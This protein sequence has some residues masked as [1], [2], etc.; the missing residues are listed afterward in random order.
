M[1]MVLRVQSLEFVQQ[2]AQ[3]DICKFETVCLP[4]GKAGFGRSSLAKIIF[5]SMIYQKSPPNKRDY[6]EQSEA[7]RFHLYN[8]HSSIASPQL[9]DFASLNIASLYHCII[10]SLYHFLIASFLSH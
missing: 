2:F 6:C 8:I 4:R 5:I 9:R 7:I 1:F 3:R 10:A